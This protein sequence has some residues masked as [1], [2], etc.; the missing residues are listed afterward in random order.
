MKSHQVTI[1]DIAKTLGISISTVSRALKN[2]PDISEETKTQVK[3][4]ARKLSYEPNALALSLR[5][6]KSNTIGVIIPEIVHYFFSSV[7]SGMEDVAYERGYNIMM[8]QS[9]EIYKREIIN[10]QTLLSNRVDG[11]LVSVSKN[12]FDFEH[13]RSFINQGIPM[14]FFDRVCPDILTDRVIINDEAGAFMAT[15]HLIQIGCKKIAHFSAPQN[16][17]IGQG[18]MAG[19]QR[20]LRQYKMDVDSKL[21]IHCD[22]SE[23]AMSLTGDFITRN[24]GVDA[25]FAVNDSTAIAAMQVIQKMNRKIPQEISIVGF[26]DGPNALICSPTLTTIEQ[27]GYEIGMEAV[28][29]LLFKIENETSSDSF[30]TKVISPNLIVRESTR[31]LTDH[32]AND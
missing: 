32:S 19:Y 31:R 3:N 10:S 22:T 27:K 13:F 15:E 14:V 24:P 12:T 11:V 25:I 9:N 17:L 29:L 6:N 26:G 30:Q 8:C 7:I 1:K 5:K 23:Y 21:I 2:H 16:L 4:L 28:K 18:R 20:A